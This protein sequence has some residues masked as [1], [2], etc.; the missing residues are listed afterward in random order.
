MAKP[1][2]SRIVL[3]SKD[4]NPLVEALVCLGGTADTKKC[5]RGPEIHS[6]HFESL[7]V[8][9]AHDPS[10][11]PAPNPP[12]LTFTIDDKQIATAAVKELVNSGINFKKLDGEDGAGI[13]EI[14]MPEAT[15]RLE[16]RG[17]ALLEDLKKETGVTTG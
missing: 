10:V 14:K 7:S 9:I 4:P 6:V 11:A 8:E 17:D 13:W 2:L 16:R 1:I 15:I 5:G 3:V 12:V